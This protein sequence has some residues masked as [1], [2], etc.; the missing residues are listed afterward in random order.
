MGL[1][2]HKYEGPAA[3]L[4]ALFLEEKEEKM[5]FINQ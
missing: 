3:S 2:L 4:Y 5:T 1:H